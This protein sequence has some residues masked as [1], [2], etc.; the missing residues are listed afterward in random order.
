VGQWTVGPMLADFTVDFLE[1]Q[2]YS[3]GVNVAAGDV[4]GDG[5]DEII[6]GAGSEPCN[7]TILKVFKGDGTF[8]GVSFV[9]YPDDILLNGKAGTGLSALGGCLAEP[10]YHS[11]VTVTTGDLDGDGIAEIITG[12]GPSPLNPSW[13]RIFRGDGTLLHDGFLAFPEAMKY[14]VKVG[15]GRVLKEG[16]EE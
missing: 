14:G 3:F 13:V 7:R 12:L 4:D 10:G 9:A 5:I 15:V 11:G 16:R 1:G 8:T 2:R 6:T